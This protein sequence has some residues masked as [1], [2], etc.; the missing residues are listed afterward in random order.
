MLAGKLDQSL[1]RQF[2]GAARMAD[3]H[4]R[5]IDASAGAVGLVGTVR[6]RLGVYPQVPA[7]QELERD[8]HQC[9]AGATS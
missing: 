1:A 5:C 4:D 9:L 8:L 6:S 2:P 7:V 3:F